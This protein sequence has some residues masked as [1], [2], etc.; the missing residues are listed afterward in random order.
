MIIFNLLEKLTQFELN[1]IDEFQINEKGLLYYCK[2]K[3]RANSNRILIMLHG[4][5]GNH[6]DNPV[7]ARWNWG[8]MY[9]ANI[10]CISD[11]TLNLYKGSTLC[12]YLG[13]ED[14]HAIEGVIRI[15]SIV[16]KILQIEENKTIFYGSS[17]GGF[18]AIMAA[19]LKPNGRAIGILPQ[20]NILSYHAGHPALNLLNSIYGT[21]NDII[22]NPNF[23]R[24]S[25]FKSYE[26][27]IKNNSKI[28]IVQNKADT[29]HYNNHFLPFIKYVNCP[30][31]GSNPEN[32]VISMIYDHPSGHA[33]EPAELIK[34]ISSKQLYFL[35]DTFPPV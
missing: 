6:N 17:G 1:E 35:M 9:D 4:N 21:N 26:F 3:L 7:Y 32:N 22:S 18:S 8:G 19:F 29:F 5:I 31:S 10:L 11:P 13:S 34:R 28:L 15:S 30:V 16:A 20:T 33:A 25:L 27:A 14:I 2:I 23:Y 12:W 24:W